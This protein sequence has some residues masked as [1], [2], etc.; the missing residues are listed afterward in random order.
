MR[1]KVKAALKSALLHL[2]EF[3][4]PRSLTRLELRKRLRAALRLSIKG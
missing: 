2:V 3:G 1:R 4:P